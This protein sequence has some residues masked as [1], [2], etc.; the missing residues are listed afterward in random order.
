M[1][2]TP[3]DKQRGLRSLLLGI[4][5]NGELYAG[6]V[7]TGFTGDEIERLMEIMAPLVQ[8]EP[9]VEGPRAAVDMPTSRAT[10]LVP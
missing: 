6:K 3:S 10:T 1:G 4:N 5:E 7:G 2:W 9:T 8:K